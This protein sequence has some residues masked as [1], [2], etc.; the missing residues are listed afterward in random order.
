MTHDAMV[1]LVRAAI[2][3]VLD[4]GRRMDG[5][6]HRPWQFDD[7]D[8]DLA[9]ANRVDFADQVVAWLAQHPMKPSERLREA[10]H[11]MGT[12]SPALLEVLG[13]HLS[14]AQAEKVVTHTSQPQPSAKHDAESH[15]LH[16]SD[17]E[18]AS[19]LDKVENEV[20]KRAAPI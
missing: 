16:M 1:A 5:G 20:A 18:L 8:Q 6:P 19:L 7:L 11:N 13:D 14:T 2:L 17:A 15:V 9:N 10:L 12:H 3:Q 4:D